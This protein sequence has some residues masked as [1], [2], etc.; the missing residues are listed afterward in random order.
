MSPYVAQA[1]SPSMVAGAASSAAIAFAVLAG[2]VVHP[3]NWIGGWGPSGIGG[4]L[5]ESSTTS[6]TESSVTW[7]RGPTAPPC[8]PPGPLECPLAGPASFHVL[9]E[10]VTGSTVEVPSWLLLLALGGAEAG[11]AWCAWRCCAQRASDLRRR[12]PLGEA[13]LQIK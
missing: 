9:G 4:V 1:K 10:G 6:T 8:P 3:A 2:V 13:R 5:W 12:Q 11:A 7:T